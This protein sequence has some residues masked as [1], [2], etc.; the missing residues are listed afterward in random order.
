MGFL[1]ISYIENIQKFNRKSQRKLWTRWQ[2]YIHTTHSRTLWFSARI[3][4]LNFKYSNVFFL[5]L[6]LRPIE[7]ETAKCLSELINF[8]ILCMQIVHWNEE[9]IRSAPSVD[10]LPVFRNRK[11]SN[12][13]K[14][15]SRK[16]LPNEELA[17]DKFNLHIEY[18][19]SNDNWALS[20][21]VIF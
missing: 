4:N 18:E 19:H 15:C 6:S 3:A 7:F 13:E 14:N 11:K 9:R 2:L 8:Y 12:G 21:F 16:L 17:V 5:V 20:T 10:P 1:L